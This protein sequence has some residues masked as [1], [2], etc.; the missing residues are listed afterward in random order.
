MLL[1]VEI[2]EVWEKSYSS[3]NITITFDIYLFIH[4]ELRISRP[5]LYAEM[6]F[7]TTAILQEKYYQQQ[8]TL[9]LVMYRN[10]IKNIPTKPEKTFKVPFL[11]RN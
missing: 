1:E 10:L 4:Y 3:V 8:I 11:F 2:L 5:V 6:K 9:I 7:V